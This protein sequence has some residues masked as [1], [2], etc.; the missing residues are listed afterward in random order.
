M[1]L[2]AIDYEKYYEE[3]KIKDRFIS[4]KFVLFLDMGYP[5]PED[6][7]FFRRPATNEYDYKR[8]DK[9]I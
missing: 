9:F 3:E 2:H 1:S 7:N 4:Q 5:K 6:I 8:R